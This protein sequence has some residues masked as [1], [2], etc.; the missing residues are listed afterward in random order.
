MIVTVRRW[1]SIAL[2][3]FLTRTKTKQSNV[4]ERQGEPQK[5]NS[6]LESYSKMIEYQVDLMFKDLT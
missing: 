6:F 1:T 5:Q 3:R 4:S 2:P